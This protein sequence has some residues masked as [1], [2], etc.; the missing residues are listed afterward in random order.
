M[1]GRQ[2]EPCG[3]NSHEYGITKKKPKT[4]NILGFFLL[5]VC[6]FKTVG[7]IS[8]TKTYPR[9]YFSREAKLGSRAGVDKIVEY[10]NIITG[11]PY[12][13]DFSLIYA[14]I[15]AGLIAIHNIQIHFHCAFTIGYSVIRY[16]LTILVI[17]KF[18]N[19]F[20]NI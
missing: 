17:I 10:T 15:I 3:K 11:P 2:N 12:L 14:H 20:H 19:I 16:H 4:A 6:F 9:F 18:K 1:D 5:G 8:I 7:D 13:R